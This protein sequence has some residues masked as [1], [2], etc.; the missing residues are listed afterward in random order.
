[1]STGLRDVL[2]LP[3]P[4]KREAS[5]QA[6]EFKQAFRAG[7]ADVNR[8]LQ[9]LAAQS[10]S[11]EY[12]AVDAQRTKLVEAFQKATGQVDP[13]NPDIM[14][15]T[16]WGEGLWISEDGG[17][18]WAMQ[19]GLP[20]PILIEGIFDANGSGRLWIATKEEGIYHTDDLGQSWTYAGFNGT[21]VYDMVFAE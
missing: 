1:M 5:K 15:A 11:K 17:D 9:A 2:G 21:M 7:M 8:D 4:S 3:E 12:Q 20:T 14:A 6:E 10:A 13:A 19:E 18:T 16:T